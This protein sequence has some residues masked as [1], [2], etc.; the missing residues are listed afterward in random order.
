MLSPFPEIG[1]EL[2]LGSDFIYRLNLATG[3]LKSRKLAEGEGILLMGQGNPLWYAIFEIER[4]GRQ[5]KGMQ[6][7]ELNR[8][9]LS[10]KPYFEF[11]E[12]DEK[13]QGIDGFNGL[14]LT[15]E[16]DGAH[17]LVGASVNNKPVLVLFGKTGVERI[18]KPEFPADC[19]I[20][21]LAWAPDGKTIYAAL[22]T[23]GPGRNEQSLV[24]AEALPAGGP[25]RLDP[26]LTMAKTKEFVDSSETAMSLSSSPDGKTLA[27]STGLIQADSLRSEQDRALFL[28]DLADSARKVTRIPVP[29]LPG[30]QAV[31]SQRNKP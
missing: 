28:I 25:V 13:K 17:L 11:W 9:D 6:F 22:I 7:G 24:I 31:S 14:T 26:V 30:A 2:F 21:S 15:P 1:G 19:R 23:P 18:I 10:L 4:P 29:G 27:I 12:A 8:D 3:D 20:A 5:D 16:P